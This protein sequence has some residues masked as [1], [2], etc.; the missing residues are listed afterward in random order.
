MRLPLPVWCISMSRKFLKGAHADSSK[1]IDYILT[2]KPVIKANGKVVHTTK[3]MI[4]TRNCALIF[5]YFCHNK[6]AYKTT[7][8]FAIII[9]T[10]T[11]PK[12]IFTHDEVPFM[13][14]F[15]CVLWM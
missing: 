6:H 12:I 14:V 1:L 3:I 4:P 8:P 2:K 5:S 11:S 15:V 10:K 9:I 7:I 13:T